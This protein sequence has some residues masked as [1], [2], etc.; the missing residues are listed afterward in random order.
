MLTQEKKVKGFS[1]LEVIVVL[2]IIGII[3]AVGM[4]NYSAWKKDR[5]V[6]AAAT[7]IINIFNGI[8][9]QL[10]RNVFP[11]M[12]MEVIVSDNQIQFLAKGL[13][14][15]RFTEEKLDHAATWNAY[16]TGASFDD[17]I[18]KTSDIDIGTP[19]YWDDL[20]TVDKSEALIFQYTSSD[21]TSDLNVGNSAI[22][23]STDGTF[24]SAAGEFNN[25]DSI[26]EVLF[27]CSRAVGA[28]CSDEGGQYHFA[29]TWN[30]F[31]NP[32]L[33]KWIEGTGW[34]VQ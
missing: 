5:E 24:Y 29:I 9:T 28:Q 30:R 14:Q 32:Q 15:K 31:G 25:A 11:F 17:S 2:V 10:Q 22:C 33:E 27:I 23:F 34:V 26:N 19:P 3:A 18:C 1:L 4:P 7:R 16:L 20:D 13:S 12:Q 6:R 8:S 21:I